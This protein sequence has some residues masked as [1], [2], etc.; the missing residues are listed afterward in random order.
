[1]RCSN[2]MELSYQGGNYLQARAFVQRYLRRHTPATAPVLWMCFNVERELDNDDSGGS[3]RGAAARRL[4]RLDR[5]R[6]SSRSSRGA[7]AGSDTAERAGRAAAA[8]KRW[9]RSC[10]APDSLK[11]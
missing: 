7:M 11:I 9:G 1:M 4:P 10:A 5:A 8:R 3:L 6:S 2:M